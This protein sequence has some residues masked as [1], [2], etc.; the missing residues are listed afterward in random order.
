MVYV[1]DFKMSG[2]PEA[3]HQAFEDLNK[4]IDLDTPKPV[5]KCLGCNHIE[6]KE[7]INGKQVRTMTYDMKDFMESSV[8]QYKE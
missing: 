3:V 1:D 6:G 8:K 5:N 4:V 2:P 7:T